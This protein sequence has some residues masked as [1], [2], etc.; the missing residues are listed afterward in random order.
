MDNLATVFHQCHTSKNHK[1]G[2]KLYDWKPK[3]PSFKGAT[4][5]TAVRL[6]LYNK[7]KELFPKKDVFIKYGAETKEIRRQRSIEKLHTNDAYCIGKFHPK[8]RCQL[9][10]L[11]KKRWNNRILQ[12]FYNAKYIDS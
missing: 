8:H 4:F 7:V 10:H 9:M 1:P 5:M 6:M 3:L 2:R 12:K 11:K